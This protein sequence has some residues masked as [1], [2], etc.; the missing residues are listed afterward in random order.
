MSPHMNDCKWNESG[1]C[2]AKSNRI[3]AVWCMA[4]MKEPCEDYEPKRAAAAARPPGGCVS[5]VRGQGGRP[6]RR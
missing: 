5:M 4:G 6:S 1:V 2:T 3:V